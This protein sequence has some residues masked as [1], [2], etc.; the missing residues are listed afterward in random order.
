MYRNNYYKKQYIQFINMNKN[1]VNTKPGFLYLNKMLSVYK[2]NIRI[3]TYPNA[4][5][6]I[7]LNKF[8]LIKFL[9]ADY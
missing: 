7:K 6:F 9:N 5:K 3:H 4:V 1:Y 2:N 8:Y